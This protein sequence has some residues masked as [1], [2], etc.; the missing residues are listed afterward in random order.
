MKYNLD[1]LNKRSRIGIVIPSFNSGITIS[2]SINS[3]LEQNFNSVKILVVDGKSTDNTLEVLQSYGDKIS[4]ICEK[5][6][7]QT[8]AI[9]KEIIKIIGGRD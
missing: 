4:W 5:D 6:K 3:V 2:D 8:D 1:I 7:G 9:N